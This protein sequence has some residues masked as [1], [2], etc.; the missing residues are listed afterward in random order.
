[1]N[2]YASIGNEIVNGSKVASYQHNVNRDMLY[3]W[4]L[5]NPT[6]TIPSYRT[7]SHF[8][9]RT[10]ADIWVED[11]SFLRLKNI[12][13]GYALPKHIVRKCGLTKFVFI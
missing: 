13:L 8:N 1:M 12:V 2:W 7:T 11:G 5:D 4:S 3:Q 10:Y 9:A 6:S